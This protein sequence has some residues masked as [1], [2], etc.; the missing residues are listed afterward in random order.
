MDPRN[1]NVR[2]KHRHEIKKKHLTSK[3]ETKEKR[4]EKKKSK[5]GDATQFLRRNNLPFFTH[6]FIPENLK[7]E[8]ISS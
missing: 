1:S 7:S 4:D 8:K 3:L 6:E 2:K 5:N